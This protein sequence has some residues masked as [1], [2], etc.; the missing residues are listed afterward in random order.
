MR[1]ASVRVYLSDA[2]FLLAYMQTRK[3]TFTAV[4]TA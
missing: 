2:L 3:L 1:V 4:S